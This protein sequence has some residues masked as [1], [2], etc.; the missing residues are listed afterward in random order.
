MATERSTLVTSMGKTE[1]LTGT[2]IF[3]NLQREMS[4]AGITGRPFFVIDENVFRLH[5]PYLA[6]GLTKFPEN[7]GFVLYPA[8]EKNK[9]LA[10]AGII[11]KTMLAGGYGRDSVIIAIGGGITG[12]IAGFAAGIYARGV[13]LVHVPTTVI[14]ATDSA[15]GGKTGVNLSG[16]K[17]MAGVF[18]HASLVLTDTSFFTTLPQEEINS[19]A[20]EIIK[21]AILTGEPFFSYL[22]KNLKYYITRNERVLRR[23]LRECVA[24]K[25][26]VVAADEREQSLRKVLNLGHTFGHAI[27]KLTRGRIAH[28]TAV[29][30]GIERAIALSRKLG[31]CTE[32]ESRSMGNLIAMMHYPP[33]PS[34][35][36]ERRLYAAMTTDKKSINATPRFVLPAAPGNILL[37]VSVGREHFI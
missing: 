25:C 22:Q 9:T 35:I 15:I 37:D 33:L 36:T 28:G 11:L 34:G 7:S 20:G 14:A 13:T 16:F 24:Y 30:Y 4:N 31:I 27:E 10:G 6:S 5:K 21:Y 1:L 18:H 19:A 12:D 29:G 3:P 2:R 17:N 32:S 26:A 23:I 8:S